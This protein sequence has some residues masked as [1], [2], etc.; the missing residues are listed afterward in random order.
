MSCVQGHTDA[1]W[2]VC[3]GPGGRQAATAGW[4][5][6]IRVWE[7]SSGRCSAKLKIHSKV[8]CMS[9]CEG[10]GG[11]GGANHGPGMGGVQR[12]LQRH[13]QGPQQGV[14][15]VFKGGLLISSRGGPAHL[16]FSC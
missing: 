2:S 12:A 16:F 1:I 6:S 14:V 15:H 3:F 11:L 8:R 7:V 5:G 13:N 10:G 4:D 9:A